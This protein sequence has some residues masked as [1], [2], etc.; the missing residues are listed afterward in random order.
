MGPGLAYSAVMVAALVTGG[1]VARLT[2]DADLPLSRVQR[3]ALLLGALGGGVIAAKLPY[4]FGDF[5]ALRSGRAWLESGRTLTLGLL[6]G[7]FGVELAKLVTGVRHKTGD[8]FVVPLAVTVGLGR[9]GCLV[10]GCCFGVE[11]DVPWAL[12][13]GDGALRHPTQIY[14]ALFHLLAAAALYR[15]GL[16]GRLRAQRIKAYYLSY[17]VF[18]FATEWLRPEPRG[19]LGLTFYQWVCLLAAPLFAW[20]WWRDARA[21]GAAPPPTA[22]A[23]A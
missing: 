17:F 15:L 5:E 20:L 10:G 2:R 1:L 22:Q 6:G 4:L 14:E 13:L 21:L 18:R 3:G 19:P 16:R 9:L 12:P 11:A 23:R 7:Y 8:G